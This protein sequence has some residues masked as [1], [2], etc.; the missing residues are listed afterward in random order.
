MYGWPPVNE[1]TEAFLTGVVGC[2]RVFGLTRRSLTT[3]GPEE[4]RGRSDRATSSRAR[5]CKRARVDPG[6][7][8]YVVK[9]GSPRRPRLLPPACPS[10]R[11]RWPAGGSSRRASSSPIDRQE[12]VDP[13]PEGTAVSRPP[14]DDACILVGERHGRDVHRPAL[15]QAGDPWRG[16]EADPT[17]APAQDCASAMD[18]QPTQVAVAAFADPA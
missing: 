6:P 15:E 7:T 5:C 1:I 13:T 4:I 2:S 16:G 18:Q 11:L 14:R 3:T 17:A 9:L 12:A 10:T 8:G